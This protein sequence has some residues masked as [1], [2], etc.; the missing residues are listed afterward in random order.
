MAS[1][2]LQKTQSIFQLADT[3]SSIAVG[4]VYFAERINKLGAQHWK[5]FSAQNYFDGAGIFTSA[6]LS[7]PLLITMVIILVS[8]PV[9]IPTIREM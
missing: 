7:G 6:V 4:L 1:G 5:K 9:K 2:G 3:W 8:L